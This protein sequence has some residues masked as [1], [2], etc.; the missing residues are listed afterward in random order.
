MTYYVL[1]DC[2]QYG[3]NYLMRE[4][5]PYITYITTSPEDMYNYIIENYGYEPEDFEDFDDLYDWISHNVEDAEL[6]IDVYKF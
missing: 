5:M 3:E 1:Y 6:V 4:G 2:D